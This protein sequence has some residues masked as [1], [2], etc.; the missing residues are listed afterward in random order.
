MCF[1]VFEIWLFG[2]G[3]DLEF[4]KGAFGSVL[5]ILS[6]FKDR[7]FFDFSQKSLPFSPKFGQIFN[8]QKFFP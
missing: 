7:K 2:F 3:K 4:F 6:Y 5:S 8:F 1:M